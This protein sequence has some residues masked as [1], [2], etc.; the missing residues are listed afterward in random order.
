[1]SPRHLWLAWACIALAPAIA[2][3][4]GTDPAAYDKAIIDPATGYRV[5][6]KRTF[7]P[8][9]ALPGG[10]FVTVHFEN[11]R[12]HPDLMTEEM[13]VRTARDQEIFYVSKDKSRWYLAVPKEIGQCPSEQIDATTPYSV[14]NSAF[15]TFSGAGVF[16]STLTS[17]GTSML[18]AKPMEISEERAT[19]A[20]YSVTEEAL[21]QLTERY[22]LAFREKQEK[23]REIQRKQEEVLAK[24][25]A[26]RQAEAKAKR[27]VEEAKQELAKASRKKA[28]MGAKDF[29][30]GRAVD[31]AP[32]HPSAWYECQNYGKATYAELMAEGWII[33]NAMSRPTGG[34]NG[35]PRGMVTD[36][37][38]EKIR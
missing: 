2:C 7:A 29:C 9:D 3:A 28:A 4:D 23:L 6:Q 13:P 15:G 37:V 20:V 1:M 8:R 30:A 32:N 19:K 34:S 38:V 33:V 35:L 25:L 22:Q 16:V 14:C 5:L 10:V 36:I 11:N 17:L 24:E 18:L 21:R 31:V 26:E 12:W 27:A